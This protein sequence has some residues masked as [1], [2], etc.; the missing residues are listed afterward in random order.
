MSPIPIQVFL[1]FAVATSQIFGGFSCCC[2]GRTFPS[3]PTKQQTGKC[4]KCSAGKNSVA[5]AVRTSLNQHHDYG[6]KVGEDGQCR[7][8]KLVIS[9][10]SPSDP[11]SLNYDTHAWV[12]PVMEMKSDHEGLIRILARHEVPFR[13]GGRSWQSIACVWKN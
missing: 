12:S 2:L 5:I 7:C 13:F 1:L 9:A 6:V 11:P 8:F 10:N 3:V 4:P